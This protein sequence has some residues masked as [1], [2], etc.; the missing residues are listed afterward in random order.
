V[1]VAMGQ[2]K[3]AERIKA[4]ARE[5]GVPTI[6]NRPLARALLAS[7]RVGTAIPPELYMAVAEVLAW[8]ISQRGRLRN[9]TA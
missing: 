8:V 4:I 9:V 3:V 2:R 1:V 7:A 6:E 5:S